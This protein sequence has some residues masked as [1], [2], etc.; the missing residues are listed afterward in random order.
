MQAGKYQKGFFR[1]ANVESTVVGVVI[2]LLSLFFV[3]YLVPNHIEEPP[4]LEHPM[5]SPKWLPTIMGWLTAGFSFLLF[6]EGIF[7]KQS[8]KSTQ[9][10]DRGP[11]LR[12]GLMI[13]ALAIYILLFETLGAVVSGVLATIVLFLAH[14]VKT[15]WVY[16]LAFVLPAV[17][18]FVFI[19]VMNVPLPLLF[20]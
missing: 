17:V 18:V 20:F 16:A 15:L 19:R 6:L 3:L 5:M 11:V 13:V 12:W 14:P 9:E 8:E 10:K 7:G 1:P 4:F 2:F